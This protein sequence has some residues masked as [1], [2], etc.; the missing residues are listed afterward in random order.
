[1]SMA[2][3]INLGQHYKRD[4]LPKKS[5]WKFKHNKHGKINNIY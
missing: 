1:M 4:T 5:N 3:K 2:E